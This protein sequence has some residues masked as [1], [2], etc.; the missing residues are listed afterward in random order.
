M[1]TYILDG[2]G[3]ASL[4]RR[5][6]MVRMNI[7]GQ[8]DCARMQALSESPGVSV[9]VHPNPG[10]MI[11]PRVDGPVVLRLLPA[12]GLAAFPQGTTIHIAMQVD[13]TG[14]QEPDRAVLTPLDVS[15][16]PFLEFASLAPDGGSVTVT[17][18]RTT[19]DRPLG[20][21]A[22]QARVQGR[23]LLGVDRV[24]EQFQINMIA[25]VDAS[26]SLR[27]TTSDGAA[28]AVLEILAG[29]STVIGSDLGLRT[30]FLGRGV[31]WV[32]DTSAGDVA[33]RTMDLLA[34]QP[35]VSGFRS[36]ARELT[37]LYPNDNTVTYVIT[38]GIPA[39]IA[40]LS[41]AGDVEGE[42]RHLVT[43]V[44]TTVSQLRRSRVEVPITVVTPALAGESTAS[45]L[46][47]QPG[48]LAGVVRSL[49]RGCFAP[50]TD[51]GTRTA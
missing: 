37:G 19:V 47:Q 9:G 35:V 31:D 15:G 13:S 25:G 12:A 39:D 34:D 5:P 3:R 51:F 16:Q 41:A 21:L 8:P 1:P 50:G 46:L 20:E 6:I 17:A 4:P 14:G 27:A 40:A 32:P 24:P 29:L 45:Q 36:A 7:D 26:A 10:L 33:R 11:V 22:H 2:T 18:L 30:C 43:L 48:A 23:A 42:A 38:D 44:P 28:E 49:L